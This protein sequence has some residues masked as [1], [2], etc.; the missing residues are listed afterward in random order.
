MSIALP[1]TPRDAN[2]MRPPMNLRITPACVS[3]KRCSMTLSRMSCS[4][5]GSL[6][7]QRQRIGGSDP[8]WR[9]ENRPTNMG[10]IV[11]TTSRFDRWL[12]LNRKARLRLR[13]NPASFRAWLR[14]RFVSCPC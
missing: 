9:P 4:A 6:S 1:A 10:R 13:I 8:G 5:H 2:E 12:D 7:D 11:Q 14:S 3:R